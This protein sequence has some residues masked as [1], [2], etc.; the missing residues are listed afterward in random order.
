MDYCN[1]L[2]AGARKVNIRQVVT[3][4]ASLSAGLNCPNIIFLSLG[5]SEGGA[6]ERERERKGKWG[7]KG[8]RV[9]VEINIGSPI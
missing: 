7:G 3:A 1:A 8:C 4:A 2:M 6:E 5:S 9:I